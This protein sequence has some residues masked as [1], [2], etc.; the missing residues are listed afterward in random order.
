MLRVLAPLIIIIAFILFTILANGKVEPTD[1]YP[2]WI[3]DSSGNH[4]DQTSGIYYL[5]THDAKKVFLTCDDIGKL[6]KLIID[7]SKTPPSIVIKEISLSNQVKKIFS[8]FRK[9]DFEGIAF[10]KKRNKIYLSV[11]GYAYDK[12]D[13][14]TYKKYE[15]V[16]VL[17]CNRDA[18]KFDSLLTIIKL[19]LPSTIFEYT[20]DNVGLEGIALTDNYLF[21]GLENCRNELQNFT[22]STFL[23]IVDRKTNEVITIST[24]D[25]NISTICGLYAVNDFELYGIDRNSRSMFRVL[26]NLDFMVD[27]IA[28]KEIDLQIPNHKDINQILGIAPESITLDEQ[29]NIYVTV[30]PWR[31]YYKPDSQDRK[32]LS[33]EELNYFKETIPIIYKFKNPF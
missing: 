18:L 16:Y 27:D 10:D 14:T 5:G 12:K 2:L 24:K 22:D 31:D 33:E 8:N 20:Q 13:P 6:N 7:E 29:N 25:L 26:F 3:I 17:S 32:Y 9:R 21:L 28:K 15:G 30:D 19:K 1:S 23:Y 11:E 4:T